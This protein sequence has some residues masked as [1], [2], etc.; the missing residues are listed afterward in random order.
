MVVG[1]R[2]VAVVEIIL[3]HV[4]GD[5][6]HTVRELIEFEN[7]HPE[8]GERD[9]K[10]LTRIVIDEDTEIALK[11]QRPKLDSVPRGAE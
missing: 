2:A 8:G 3:A 10:P 4:T 7:A 5:G 9:V 6:G 1:D 11:H